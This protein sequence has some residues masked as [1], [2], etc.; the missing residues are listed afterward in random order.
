MNEAKT[1]TFEICFGDLNP[2]AQKRFLEFVGED[3]VNDFIPLTI[4]EI[5]DD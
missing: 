1:K 4:I 5:E 3:E 2:D